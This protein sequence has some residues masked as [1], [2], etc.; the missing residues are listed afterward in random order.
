MH[1]EVSNRDKDKAKDLHELYSLV[2]L[3]G[4]LTRIDQYTTRNSQ[5]HRHE[6]PTLKFV[7]YCLGLCIQGV[8]TSTIQMIEY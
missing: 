3:E 7:V 6:N 8:F 2:P 1:F 4:V 5:R